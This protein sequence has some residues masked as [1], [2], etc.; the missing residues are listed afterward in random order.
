MMDDRGNAI[1][2][3]RCMNEIEDHAE[4]SPIPSVAHDCS[5][6]SATRLETRVDNDACSLWNV[7]SFVTSHAL[8]F[9]SSGDSTTT[10]R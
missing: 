9:S 5:V 1:F 10:N 7:G 2:S 3:A 6:P 8:L 4:A